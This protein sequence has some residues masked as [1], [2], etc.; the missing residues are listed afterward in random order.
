M[1][2]DV[3]YMTVEQMQETKIEKLSKIGFWIALA[4]SIIFITLVSISHYYAIINGYDW[5]EYELSE[6]VL[7]S[8]IAK[9]LFNI[10]CIQYGVSILLFLTP[11][12]FKIEKNNNRIFYL[13][14]SII[15]S[16]TLI[17]IGVFPEDEFWIT[18]YVISVIFFVTIG[19][20]IAYLTT[21]LLKQKPN[22]SKGFII[23][24]Y[25]TFGFLIFHVV[26]RWFFGKSFTQRIAIFLVMAYLII[27]GG[28]LAFKINSSE[29]NLLSL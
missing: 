12:A 26:T 29:R 10:A 23:F 1:L 24:G 17:G 2:K 6:L 8:K 5:L 14:L 19:I 9:I 22:I 27:A 25:F 16:V 7:D 20:L 18:H 13:L 21:L 11:L 4:S 28:Y 15:T 3:S